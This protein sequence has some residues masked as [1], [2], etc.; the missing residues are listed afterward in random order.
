MRRQKPHFHVVGVTQNAEG[1]IEIRT[2]FSASL[3]ADRAS[4]K[5]IFFD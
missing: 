2:E 1:P 5:A 4:V 3:P